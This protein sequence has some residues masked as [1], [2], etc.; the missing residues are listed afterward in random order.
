MESLKSATKKANEFLCV[1]SMSPTEPNQW[2]ISLGSIHQP[3][4]HPMCGFQ[5]SSNHGNPKYELCKLFICE[6]IGGT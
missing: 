6:A 3:T 1:R 4:T 2:H 5:P